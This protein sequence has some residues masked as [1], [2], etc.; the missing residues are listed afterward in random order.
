MSAT[1]LAGGLE[2]VG[3]NI[4]VYRSDAVGIIQ[5]NIARYLSH[6]RAQSIPSHAV[7]VN[8]GIKIKQEKGSLD[9]GTH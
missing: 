5:T 6:S 2:R 1:G 7:G 9:I 4:P 8:Q 3:S